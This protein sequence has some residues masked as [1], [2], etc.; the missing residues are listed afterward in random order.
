[1]SIN[2][3][4]GITAGDLYWELKAGAKFVVYQYCVSIILLTFRRTSDIYFVRAGQH[5]VSRGLPYTLLS[6]LFG[7][8][9]IPWGPIWT[10]QS[11]AVNLG[12]GRDVTNEV[13]GSFGGLYGDPA[14][15]AA[16]LQALAER[17]AGRPTEAKPQPTEC[18]SAPL[19]MPRL[20]NGRGRRITK[21]VLKCG[22]AVLLIWLAAGVVI[23]PL[24]EQVVFP[25]LWQIGFRDATLIRSLTSLA[26]LCA[27]IGVVVLVYRDEQRSQKQP[28]RPVTTDR[29]ALADQLPLTHQDDQST[30]LAMTP[31]RTQETTAAPTK[32]TRTPG[33]R[34][35]KVIPLA[36]G[37][38]ALLLLLTCGAALLC[39][40]LKGCPAPP[41]D[42]IVRVS[43][44][45]IAYRGQQITVQV[46]V[47]NTGKDPRLLH[48]IYVG[49][50]YARGV[51]ISGSKPSFS[52]ST[53]D[54]GV[55]YT[56]EFLHSIAG[57]ETLVVVFDAVAVQHGDFSTDLQ[58]CIDTPTK[59]LSQ[60]IRTVVED[61][62][63][64][65]THTHTPTATPTHT[66]TLTPTPTDTATPTSTSTP[67]HTPVPPPTATPRTLATGT[68]IKQIMTGD[69][70]GE[71]AIENGNDID[72]VAVLS[73]IHGLRTLAVYVGA[74]SKFTTVT[75]IADGTYYLYFTL[76]ED[77]D[78]NSARF[79]RRVRFFRFEDTFVFETKP[80]QGGE[81]Y[82]RWNVTLHP[83]EGGTAETPPVPEG[84]FPD[85]RQ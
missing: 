66:A 29:H 50:D 31:V 24:L 85:L 43:C 5:A 61:A 49:E 10:I 72:S 63:V 78:S 21:H 65:P 59:C 76:G 17:K 56:Y 1:M 27:V 41:E 46:E 51:A 44:P 34:R 22:C 18:A 74:H 67:T 28:K 2:G 42:I 64:T 13:V 6:L 47:Q 54:V 16:W 26:I 53:H 19:A 52:R 45:A 80:I 20:H 55:E 3:I 11:L 9:G 8:W 79:T 14:V 12:G 23:G 48:S 39:A 77:W 70:C 57:Q 62:T 71:L 25:V 15:S 75:C 7:W 68:L 84:E 69:G 30:G 35:R 81:E 40:L 32:Q 38:V 58:V 82:T 60:A 83:V 33:A 73:G 4:E 36:I 37:S